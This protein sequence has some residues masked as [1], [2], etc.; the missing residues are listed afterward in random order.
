VNVCVDFGLR[1]DRWSRPLLTVLGTG[2]KRTIIRVAGG[3][4]HVKFGWMLRIDVPLEDIKFAHLEPKRCWAVGLHQSGDHWLVNGSR[5]GVV[6]IALT[7]PVH[8]E[9]TTGSRLFLIPGPV[10]VLYHSLTEP[11]SFVAALESGI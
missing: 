6:K 10:R 11:E 2:P 9:K 5:H 7:R 3:T 1:Y 8:P 4:L